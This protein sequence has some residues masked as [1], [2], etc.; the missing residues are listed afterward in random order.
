MTTILKRR[1]TAAR[2]WTAAAAG[3]AAIALVA[4]GCGDDPGHPLYTFVGDRGPG[5]T[6]G[7]GSD[8]F[9]AEWYVLSAAGDAVETGE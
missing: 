7:Q 9:G 3:V 8:G 1:A 2:N 6:A 5:Q 4:A